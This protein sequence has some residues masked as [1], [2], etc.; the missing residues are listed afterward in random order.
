[1]EQYNKNLLLWFISVNTGRQIDVTY[2]KKF[3]F[4]H[5]PQVQY[6]QTP[7]APYLAIARVC[8]SAHYRGI[9]ATPS[10]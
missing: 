5:P 9:L 6:A 7:I 10:P 8:S 2:T 1:M 3:N 4:L